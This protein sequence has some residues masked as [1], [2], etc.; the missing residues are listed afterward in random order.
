[1]S[2]G[3]WPHELQAANVFYSYADEDDA[4]RDA[5]EKQLSILRRQGYA[6]HGQCAIV[7]IPQAC[8]YRRRKASYIRK[9]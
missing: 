1:M 6:E 3:T 9:V 5:L 4:L 7:F 2:V 8:Y